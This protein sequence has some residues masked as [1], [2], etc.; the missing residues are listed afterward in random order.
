MPRKLHLLT[1]VVFAALL[2]PAARAEGGPAG[3]W[4]YHFTE[5]DTSI[6]MLFLF[7]ETDKKWVGDYIGASKAIRVEPKITALT[8]TG[9]TLGRPVRL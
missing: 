1:A 9:G 5:G 3:N 6:T 2:A 7:T 8:V 4:K